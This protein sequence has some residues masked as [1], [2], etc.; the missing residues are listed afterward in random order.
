MQ[1]VAHTNSHLLYPSYA[2]IVPN[3][4]HPLD[5]RTHTQ[6]FQLHIMKNDYEELTA[7]EYVRIQ[8]SFID[9]EQENKEIERCTHTVQKVSMKLL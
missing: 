2:Y 6:N 5:T 3:C 7:F 4:K 8:F 9:Q 1:S